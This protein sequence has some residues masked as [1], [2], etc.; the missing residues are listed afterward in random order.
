MP[1]RST[2]NI[3]TMTTQTNTAEPVSAS[4]TGSDLPP[5]TYEPLAG[6]HIAISCK[7]AV[8]LA[9]NSKRNVAFTFNDIPLLVTPDS[10]PKVIEE[11]WNFESERRRKEYEASPEA[12]VARDKRSREVVEMQATCDNLLES[13]PEIL[14]NCPQAEHVTWLKKFAIIADDVDVKFSRPPLIAELEWAGYEASLYVGQKPEWFNTRPRM[15]GY[16]FGQAL[17]CLRGG[18]PP[19]PITVSFCDKYFALPSDDRNDQVSNPHPDK[20]S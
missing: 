2:Q 12:G 9:I 10:V 16:I 11:C 6:H 7:E 5:L 14:R 3:R 1:H 4:G 20:I 19:H 18:M 17:S 15:A 13:L 8:A